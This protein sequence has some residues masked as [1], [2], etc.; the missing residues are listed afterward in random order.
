MKIGHTFWPEV[1]YSPFPCIHATTTYTAL[2]YCV[3]ETAGPFFRSIG[4][5]L[6]KKWINHRMMCQEIT[7]GRKASKLAGALRGTAGTRQPTGARRP[8][9]G[10]FWDF[11]KKRLLRDFGGFRRTPAYL[12]VVLITFA[13]CRARANILRA[14]A[15]KE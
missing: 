12:G 8:A 11:G 1:Q 7:V 2:D 9:K 3:E 14:P 4:D 10:I 6:S 5:F 13:K 15:R